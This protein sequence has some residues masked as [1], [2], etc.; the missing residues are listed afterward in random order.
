MR[1]FRAP[2]STSGST[3][4]GF[5]PKKPVPKPNFAWTCLIFGSRIAAIG[6]EALSAIAEDPETNDG[7][8]LRGD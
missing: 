2:R 3:T 1:W 6:S 7:V 8:K 4:R 5:W